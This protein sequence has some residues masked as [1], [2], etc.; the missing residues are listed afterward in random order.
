[1]QWHSDT[2]RASWYIYG[3]THPV[4]DHHLSPNA[5]NEVTALIPFPHL[6]DGTPLT[7]TFSLAD[8]KDEVGE[9]YKYYHKAKGFRYLF[10]LKDIYDEDDR[11]L[12]LF[13]ELLKSEFHGVRATIER[14]SREGRKDHVDDVEAKGGYVGGVEVDR[15]DMEMGQ[16]FRV[17]DGEGES[18]VYD[19]VAWD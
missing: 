19:V 5:W 11:D 6:W 4:K 14:Y 15:G 9:D 13:P 10:V 3:P 17:T 2:N 16:L 1:M 7:T 12:C 18:C 8:E